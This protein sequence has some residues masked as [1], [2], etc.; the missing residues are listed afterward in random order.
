MCSAAFTTVGGANAP[1]LSPT[2][3]AAL[4]RVLCRRYAQATAVKIEA[5]IGGLH[6]SMRPSSLTTPASER[7][8]TGGFSTGGT[9]IHG[10]EPFGSP[11]PCVLA[12]DCAYEPFF[13]PSPCGLS[14]DCASHTR[15]STL[16]QRERTPG[17]RPSCRG[18]LAY[19]AVEEGAKA[20]HSI[21]RTPQGLHEEKGH[22]VRE[23]QKENSNTEN[24]KALPPFIQALTACMNRGR[25]F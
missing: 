21:A 3:C 13:S 9:A 10:Y 20:M 25:A 12:Q 15:A 5:A 8:S 11:S 1:T 14:Q 7:C 23:M 22:G 19:P 4:P 6:F 16:P 18:Q 17:A 2:H 24:Q